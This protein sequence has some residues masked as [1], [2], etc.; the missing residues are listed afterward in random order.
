[1]SAPVSISVELRKPCLIAN[2][3]RARIMQVTFVPEASVLLLAVAQLP[4]IIK[5]TTPLVVDMPPKSHLQNGHLLRCTIHVHRYPRLG[6]HIV[7]PFTSHFGLAG[8]TIAPLIAEEN[9]VAHMEAA[10]ARVE[11]KAMQTL[12]L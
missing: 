11:A 8:L 2:L 1:M 7:R 9:S 12:A 5:I 4:M 6:I 3:A 10:S